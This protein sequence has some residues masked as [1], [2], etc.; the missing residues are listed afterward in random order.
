[1]ERRIFSRG[2]P[3]L[4]GRA[5]T[6]QRMRGG[7][8]SAICVAVAATTAVA[9][10]KPLR[11]GP[12]TVTVPSGWSAQT[13]VVPVRINSPESTPAGFFSA[14]FFSPEQTSQDLR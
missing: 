5:M 14:Q 13:N 2:H 8:G 4:G 9:Q 12:L 6:A 10:G 3:S 7:F 1:M 11:L